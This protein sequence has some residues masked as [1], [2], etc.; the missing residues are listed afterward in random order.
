MMLSWFSFENFEKLVDD[1]PLIFLAAS[2]SCRALWAIVARVVASDYSE[3]TVA[4]NALMG[5]ELFLRMRL[6]S[7][8]RALRLGLMGVEGEIRVGDGEMLDGGEG[9]YD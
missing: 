3:P 6:C 7:S 5:D 1:G 9:I 4:V 2:C 8:N